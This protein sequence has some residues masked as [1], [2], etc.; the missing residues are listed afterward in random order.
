VRGDPEYAVMRATL[1]ALNRR[2]AA[3]VDDPGATLTPGSTT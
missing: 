1:D 2:V 3:M